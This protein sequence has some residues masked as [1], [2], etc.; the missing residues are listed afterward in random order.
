MVPA[1][2]GVLEILFFTSLEAPLRLIR[3]RWSI[4]NGWPWARYA[5]G[6]GAPD[7]RLLSV[8]RHEPAG[9]A[10]YRSVRP[11]LRELAY[12]IPGRSR[13]EEWSPQPA[14]LIALLGSPGSL[15]NK[16]TNWARLFVCGV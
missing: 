3:H 2:C 1:A 6:V 4:N 9:G 8:R 11:G 16:Q 13:W 15:A 12:D 7:V 5:N 14:H 10:C